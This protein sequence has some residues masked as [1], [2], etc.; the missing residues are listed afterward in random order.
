M[1]EIDIHLTAD[2]IPVVSH[3]M[4]LKRTANIEGAIAQT[5]LAQLRNDAPDI[6]SLAE[7]LDLAESLG[8][9]LYIE[10]KAQG[11]GRVVWAL[12]EARNFTRAVI[13]SF[14]AAEIRALSDAGC[15][16]PLATLV[17]LGEDP[18]E[19]AAQSGADII[20]L[21][22]EKGGDRPQDLVTNALLDCAR[23]HD[24]GVV[25][26][27][28]ERKGVLDA[29]MDLPVLGICTNQPELMRGVDR[30]AGWSTQIVCHR[31]ANA[32]APENTLA[33]A[34]L[35]F[36]QGAHYVEID[37]RP[38]ADGEIVVLHDPTLDRTTNGTGEIT[39][40]TL[41]TLET[42]S[43]GSW[44][45]PFYS[46]QTIPTLAQA[47]ALARSYGRKLYIENK[48]VDAQKLVDFV[49]AHDFL[50]RC[51]F[52]SGDEHLQEAMRRA[53]PDAIIKANINRYAD[54]A[55]MQ[56]HLAPQLTEIGYSDY[57]RLAPRCQDAGIIPM[58]QYFGD[59]RAIFDSI[60]EIA[61]P[62]INLDRADLLIA[63]QRKRLAHV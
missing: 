43:A 37:V 16:Y 58:M 10:T 17:P 29:I 22:W 36:D 15:P 44:F 21:C 18:F 63:A 59:D 61:P 38:T 51:F 26:W 50:D 4:D 53:A 49:S 31:G 55:E 14:N 7:T 12:L 27:H 54:I 11:A 41:A 33:A 6:P 52:W 23:G 1:W 34:R 9:A 48:S 39:S 13:G 28:E 57:L 40:H 3:D 56:A 45:S 62:M 2:R 25:L 46:D 19:R 35:S 42:L 30:F 60:V 47:I 20:H 8:Q 32:F 5:T 24:L